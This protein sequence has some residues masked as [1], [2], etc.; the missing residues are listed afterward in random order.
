MSLAD[1]K[2]GYTMPEVA[3]LLDVPASRVRAYVRAGFLKPVRG[4]RGE[5]R[6]SFQ[7]LILLRAANELVRARIA[8]QRVR[9]ALRELMRRLPDGRRLSGLTITADGK[10]IVVRD[11]AARWNP[12]SGQRLFD[13]QV[14]DIARRVAPLGGL[15]ARVRERK[16]QSA[17]AWYEQGCALESGSPDEARESYA[18]ALELDPDHG[19]AHVNLGR[20]LHEAGDLEAAETHY[21]RALEIRP[22][23]VTA[24]FNLGVVLEDLGRDLEALEAYERALAADRPYADAHYNIACLYE[25]LGRAAPA[26]RHLKIY[27]TLTRRR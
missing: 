6:F 3:R 23:D 8:P 11:G 5:L 1:T 13:F 12:E 20:L 16:Q 10:T 22:D 15:S 2:A 14:A 7:D 18:K 21:R 24:A 9:R 27:R 26:V 17:E 4:S 19:D 25:R